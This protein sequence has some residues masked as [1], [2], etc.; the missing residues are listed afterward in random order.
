MAASPATRLIVSAAATEGAILA[1]FCAS[2]SI[3]V[4]RH[5][6]GLSGSQY[7]MIFL[8]QVITAVIGALIA[9]RSAMRLSRG[10][11]LRAGFGLS[12]VG[13]LV[14]SF[15]ALGRQHS[16]R[17][18]SSRPAWSVAASDSSIRL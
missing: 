2:V 16:C 6:Y 10:G 11:A 9:A 1:S 13:L 18:F 3:L 8:L 17:C 12:I 14:P 5:G 15:R 4:G 7:S